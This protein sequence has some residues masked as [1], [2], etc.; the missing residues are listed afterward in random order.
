[1]VQRD[2]ARKKV[3]DSQ[4]A[5]TLT[6]TSDK[7]TYLLS[8]TVY[9]ILKTTG[10]ADGE[11]SYT[12]SYDRNGEHEGSSDAVFSIIGGEAAISLSGLTWGTYKVTI[13]L[14]GEDASVEFRIPPSNSV[15]NNA[16]SLYSTTNS[17]TSSK[18][19]CKD[20][21]KDEYGVWR[22]RNSSGQTVNNA[23]LCGD[24]IASSGQNNWYFLDTNGEMSSNLVPDSN[25][26]CYSLVTA[27]NGTY[28]MLRYTTNGDYYVNGVF[29]DYNES[30]NGSFGATV[31]NEFSI[32]KLKEIYGGTRYGIG[33]ENSVYTSNF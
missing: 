25:G 23:W 27:A 30:H 26:N 12:L 14:E 16:A 33:N 1:M 24:A 29:L 10:L 21:Y 9:L 2:P 15:S 11:Y 22:I 13:G 8:E 31:P 3:S 18:Y 28:G 5:V 4:P 17:S 20:W 32:D 7:D 19:W 6:L